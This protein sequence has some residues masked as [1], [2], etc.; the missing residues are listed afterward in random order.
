[1]SRYSLLTQRAALSATLA[2]GG[3][4]AP[5][6]NPRRIRLYHLVIGSEDTP[7]NVANLWQLQRTTTAG[8]WTNARTPQL[9]DPADTIAAVSV[10]HD[11]ATA[12]PTATAN[13]FPL[14]F[15]A[16][17]QSTIIWTA[18]QDGDIWIP[19][20]ASAGL[21]LWTPTA[22]NAVKATGTWHFEER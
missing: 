21:M 10:G 15:A 3:L 9:L 4:Q 2:V 19:A 17:M 16:N 20:T 5:A 13:A 12:N 11:T 22:P 8:T 7:A 14:S 18:P 6:S 1:M